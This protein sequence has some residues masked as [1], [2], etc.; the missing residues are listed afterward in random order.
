[1]RGC[2]TVLCVA[3][4]SLIGGCLVGGGW[5]NDRAV[6]YQR[7]PVEVVRKQLAA[8]RT[9]LLAYKQAHGRYPTNDEGP[10]VLDTFQAR[11]PIRVRRD[12]GTP[13]DLFWTYLTG[14]GLWR[15][16]SEAVRSFARQHGRVPAS[17][18]ELLSC[19]PVREVLPP[20]AD[21]TAS[22]E[23]DVAVADGG[24]V[25]LID[26]AGVL[27]PCMLHYVYENRTGLDAGQFDGSPAN[28]DWRRRYSVRVDDGVYVSSIDGRYWSR[29]LDDA[30]FE[31]WAPVV[32][33]LVMVG[34]AIGVAISSAKRST[35]A[36]AGAVAG[37][38]VA[39]AV[40]VAAGLPALSCYVV[41][42]PFDHRNPDNV[43]EQRELLEKFHA[44]GAIGDAT[45][46]RLVSA[47]DKGPLPAEEE[48]PGD[49][50]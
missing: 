3:P 13:G 27:S 20:D 15:G 46:E 11:F 1:M 14:V 24:S 33:G 5:F 45:Y 4:I 28:G 49:P 12:P 37:V 23:L 43:Q 39:A 30:L 16:C 22:V 41:S 48:A 9:H 32:L 47:M 21:E 26:D 18:E 34:V 50:E 40:G 6:S 35:G 19:G 10:V 31:R 8:L 7:R 2:W 29:R 36:G 25:L 17:A 38:A 42:G 44:R